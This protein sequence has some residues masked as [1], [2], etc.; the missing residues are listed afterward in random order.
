MTSK[1]AKSNRISSYRGR[2]WAL[3]RP[4][5]GRVALIA[6]L[7]A[8]TGALEAVFLVAVSRTALS[9]ADGRDKT[10]ILAGTVFTIG[11]ALVVAVGLLVARL[12]LSLW[13]VS[14]STALSELVGSTMRHELADAYL[15]TSWSVQ[16][17]EPGG[18]LQQVVTSFVS[19]AVGVVQAFTAVMTTLLI[20]FALLGVAIAVDPVAS[21]VVIVALFILGSVLA[22]I[23]L[24]IRIRSRTLRDAQLVFTKSINELSQLGL[25]MQTFGVR[26]EFG[27]RIDS[28]SDNLAETQTKARVLGGALTHMYTFL[29]FGAVVM[30]LSVAA[31]V[32]VRELSALGAVMLVMLRSLA[33]GQQLQ[34]SFGALATSLPFLEELD[35]TIERYRKNEA[36]NGTIPVSGIGDIEAIDVTYSY[37]DDRP[38]LR[39]VSF[40]IH[41]GEIVGVIG[42]SGSGKS[43][44]V[45]LLLGLR[46]P[47][48]GEITIDGTLLHDI[49]RQ[50]WTKEVAFVSQEPRLFT[51][52]VAE[53][54]RF[55]RDGIDDDTVQWAIDMS[56]LAQDIERLP[57]G[58]ITHIGERGVELS[59]GQRQ[60]LSIARALAGKPHCIILDE[61]T[62]ALDVHSESSIREMLGNMRG[63]ATVIVIAHRLSTLNICDRIMVID[64]GRLEAFDTPVRLQENNLYFRHALEVSG[65]T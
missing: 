55:F 10:G 47:T 29:A 12:V 21:L 35:E 44:L 22:P 36:T 43:T 65:I 1:T 30:G 32:G 18:R 14:A 39:E 4:F 34:G 23:R 3:V 60:R 15:R 13:T 20:L 9:I 45:Q 2:V 58:M 64:N 8:L 7:T 50:S 16:Q 40:R 49:D 28:L 33:Y 46:E 57:E 6:I 19:E 27:S 56:N 24:R 48:T 63:R 17:T 41:A 37:S 52:T 38:A 62:S 51:G 61:P 59:G 5:R 11:W 54:I 25:E 42:H 26:D 31:S 53:N